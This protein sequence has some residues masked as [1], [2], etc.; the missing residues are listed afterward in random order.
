MSRKVSRYDEQA[1][2]EEALKY[3]FPW[4]LGKFNNS[5]YQKLQRRGMLSKIYNH[6]K[7]AKR[8]IKECIEIASRYEY[9]CDLKRADSGAYLVLY[10][11]GLLSKLF[12]RKKHNSYTFE[13]CEKEASLY[14]SKIGFCKGSPKHYAKSVKQE[15]I[16][17]FADKFKYL[18]TKA[19]ILEN[20]VENGSSVD[21]NKIIEV[22]KKFDNSRKF[23]ST[24]PSMYNLAV[25]R[26][27]ISSFDWLKKSP[28]GWEDV[29][30]VYEFSETH[31]AYVGRTGRLANRDY[32]HKHN[33]NDP[34]C[35]Y[36][37]KIGVPV[38]NPKI[39]NR[40][41]SLE[42]G[43]VLECEWI[44]KYTADGWKLLNRKSGGGA[45]NIGKIFSKNKVL[46]IASRFNS[47]K[48]L[49]EAH[50]E[51]VQVLYSHD[52]IDECTWLEKIHAPKVKRGFWNVCENVIKEA[53]KYNTLREFQSNS[54]G[55]YTGAV[56]NGWLDLLGF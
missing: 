33:V 23:R 27:L 9:Q 7:N 16:S 28:Q 48:S 17:L 10:K 47:L 12:T 15:W 34:V 13:E 24:E 36:A 46:S 4:E 55:A 50:P 38:P 5:V 6:R 43:K 19:A 22:A 1:C 8:S 37:S 21:N 30:Y 53:S 45:G 29:V 41:L 2:I 42:R 3:E 11:N 14:H 54:W 56:R 40:G 18:S 35:C 25:K 44:S 51:V 31:I 49:R 52:W 32:E 26:H 20:R 39:L